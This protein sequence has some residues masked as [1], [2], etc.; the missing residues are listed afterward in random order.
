MSNDINPASIEAQIGQAMDWGGQGER[1]QRLLL[2][3]IAKSILLLHADLQEL[4][5]RLKKISLE[6]IW[7][8]RAA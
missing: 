3:A 6:G 5:E 7:T 8:K 4:N 1:G 2:S